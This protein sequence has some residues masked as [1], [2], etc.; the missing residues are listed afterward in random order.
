MRRHARLAAWLALLA[1][2]LSV[3]GVVWY[4]RL[5]PLVWYWNGIPDHAP[6]SL[7]LSEYRVTLEAHPIA[8]ITANASALTYNGETDTLFTTINNPP[9]I[10]ELTREGTVLRKLPVAGVDDLEG[11][12][13]IEGNLFAL[14]DERKQQIVRVEIDADTRHLDAQGAPRLGL[15]ILQSGNFGFEGVTWDEK[16]HRLLVAKEKRPRVF[17]IRGLPNLMDR[18]D[19]GEMNL[20]IHEWQ[21]KQPFQYFLRDLSSLSSDDQSS[22]ILLLSDESRLL[23]EYSAEGEL[24]G[25]MPLWR[26]WHGLTA[27]VPQAEGVTVGRDGTVYLIS[28]PNLFYRFERPL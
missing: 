3:V 24:V 14:I 1:L 23:V 28:E 9:Q 26:G 13:H 18:Q 8:G 27:F 15:G 21:P 11:I 19:D 2:L 20:Q 25:L 16:N 7:K 4:Y 6:G 10:V 12:T 17:E 22:R 5:I